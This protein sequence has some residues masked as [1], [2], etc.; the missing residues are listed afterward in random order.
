MKG[1]TWFRGFFPVA[2]KELKTTLLSIRLII[3]TTILAL[4][5]L[6]GTYAVLPGSTGPA[7]TDR[8]IVYSF[9]YYPDLNSSN[10]AL[11]AVVTSPT[12]MH[13]SGIKVQLVNSTFYTSRGPVQVLET[14]NTDSSG[15]ARFEQLWPKYARSQLGLWLPDSSQGSPYIIGPKVG[16]GIR[17]N[18][19]GM[20]EMQPIQLANN[21]NLQTISLVF[22]GR[23]G[24]LLASGD[25]FLWNITATLPPPGPPWTWTPPGGGWPNYKIGSTD[26]T[27]YYIAP[28]PIGPGN[29]VIRAQKGNLNGTS[30]YD[31]GGAV[32]TPPSGPETPLALAGALFMPI[33]L[34]LMALALGY[35]AIARE[36]SEGSLD[37]L[38]SKPISRLGVAA[39]KVLG[40]FTSALVP[41][42]GVILA[43]AGLVYAVTGRASS[44]SFLAGL[45]G[46]SFFLVLSYV[47]IFL[48]VSALARSLGTAVLF[49]VIL[50][51]LFDIF[52]NL[53]GFL[54][55]GN[56]GTPGSV[57][58]YQAM[59]TVGLFSPTGAYLQLLSTSL[60]GIGVSAFLASSVA[61]P[62]PLVWV[63]L[64]VGGWTVAPLLLFAWAMKYRVTEG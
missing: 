1:P 8:Q 15:L 60:S 49:S 31:F 50:F 26:A 17:L 36:R 33:I 13:L 3:M 29:Y 63:L 16:T 57:S 25:V 18:N 47:L 37:L 64:S 9:A 32:S 53:I 58:W 62:L 5:F 44:G 45:L 43:A 46:A 34:P 27:G 59:Q 54:I 10:P 40:T 52:W 11:A 23:N 30:T 20:V 42:V 55:A 39:G 24:T 28:K 41:V 2:S 19:T 61:Q 56:V 6:A 12:G 22:A 48:T 21:L 38:M 14:K 51:L 4:A 35:D 7:G